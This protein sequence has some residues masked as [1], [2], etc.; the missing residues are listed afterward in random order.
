MPTIFHNDTTRARGTAP[1]DGIGPGDV[2]DRV[3]EFCGGL[4]NQ[5]MAP[6]HGDGSGRHINRGTTENT[7][8]TEGNS[9]KNRDSSLITTW[10]KETN[11]TN[12]KRERGMPEVSCG[13]TPAPSLTLRVGM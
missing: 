6:N 1:S 4:N 2:A 11:H 3:V 9:R 8:I 10:S 13:P 7:E 12:P 5:V